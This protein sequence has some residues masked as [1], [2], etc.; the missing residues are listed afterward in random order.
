[1]GYDIHLTRARDWSDNAEARI[2]AEEWLRVVEADPELSL[3][4]YNGDY[5]TLWTG[6]SS[7]AEP[8]FDWWDG[9]VQTKNPDPAMIAKLI[10]LAERLGGRVQGDD[11]ET[12][13]ADGRM[14]DANGKTLDGD[15]R[16]P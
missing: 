2:S 3:A 15:W 14:V 8:W 12:F 1:M 16:N 7:H 10:Q 5:F 11:G 9:N 4:G 6:P 13:L